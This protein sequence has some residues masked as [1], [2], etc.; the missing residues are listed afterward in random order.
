MKNLLMTSFL[1]IS[2]S[3][4]LTANAGPCSDFFHGCA[5]KFYP[6]C[7][8]LPQTNQDETAAKS[9]CYNGVQ[10]LCE[11]AAYHKFGPKVCDSENPASPNFLSDPKTDD[12][13][14]SDNTPEDDNDAD[15]TDHSASY[16]VR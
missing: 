13:S 11:N 10:A 15:T 1:I 14:G 6:V 9:F 8:K 3:L 5:Q 4:S 12:G 2:T 7:G 16:S